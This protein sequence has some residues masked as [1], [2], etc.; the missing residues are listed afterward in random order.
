MHAH[1]SLPLWPGSV[2]DLFHHI[3]NSSA[4]L[5]SAFVLNCS[6]GEGP[7]KKTAMTYCCAWGIQLLPLFLSLSPEC[8]WTS[9]LPAMPHPNSLPPTHPHKQINAPSHVSTYKIPSWDFE[10]KGGTILFHFSREQITA[11]FPLAWPVNVFLQLSESRTAF[12]L[13]V[14]TTSDFWVISLHYLFS[15]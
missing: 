3:C 12:F 7:V 13:S 15:W 11:L 4:S 8:P 10:L 1:N 5:V 2:L 14:S 6:S 9:P